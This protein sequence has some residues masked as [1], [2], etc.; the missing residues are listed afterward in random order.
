MVAREFY[1]AKC[2]QEVSALRDRVNDMVKTYSANMEH[3]RECDNCDEVDNVSSF[4]T[5]MLTRPASPQHQAAY[6]AVAV[7]M[8]Y[9]EREARGDHLS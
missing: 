1:L 3:I 2:D 4:I 8:L 5:D 9:D 6:L 7:K